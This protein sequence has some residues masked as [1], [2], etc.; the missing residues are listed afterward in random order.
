[1]SFPA[2]RAKAYDGIIQSEILKS[3]NNILAIEYIK[4]AILQNFDVQFKTVRRIG[5]YHSEDMSAEYASA[6]AIRKNFLS[7]E[8]F[9]VQVPCE[10][11]SLYAN[12]PVFDLKKLN[13]TIMYLLRS[14]THEQLKQINDVSEGLEN[15]LKKYANTCDGFDS[16]VSCL[17]GKRYTRTKIS[18][19]LVSILLGIDKKIIYKNPSYARVLAFNDTGRNIIKETKENIATVV[20]VA[21]F[22]DYCDMFQKDILATDTAFLCSNEKKHGG[23]DFL[24]SPC[25]IHS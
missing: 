7:G 13:L 25:Y 12:A 16:L 19:I 10:V 8:D 17:S 21:D 15:A 6:T 11:K 5:D 9:S 14:M 3:P 22:T 20:K 4:A 2:A 1:M 23:I 18:R 24:T